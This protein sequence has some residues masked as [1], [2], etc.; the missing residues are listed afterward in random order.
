M[1]TLK[2]LFLGIQVDETWDRAIDRSNP[3]LVQLFTSGGD[4]LTEVIY[5]ENRYLGKPLALTPTF[6]ELERFESHIL[7]LLRKIAPN[8]PFSKNSPVL[9]AL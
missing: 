3:H 1:F 4:Y 8:Y 7:S 5:K 6:S 2:Q 9:V